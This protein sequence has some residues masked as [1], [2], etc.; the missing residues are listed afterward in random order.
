M[1]SITCP[2]KDSAKNFPKLPA[3][4]S[5]AKELSFEELD[6]LVDTIAI[7]L[8][9]HSLSAGSRLGILSKNSENMLATIFA[10]Q[11]IGATSCLLNLQL[12][13]D[14]WVS[15][16]EQAKCSVIIGEDEYL[17]SLSSERQ[18]KLDFQEITKATDTE[19]EILFELNPSQE[20][21]IIFT[22][23][24]TGHNKGVRLSV[25]NLM[26]SAEA[27]NKLT[28]LTKGD[29]WGVSLPMYHLGGLGIIYRTLSAGA[30]AGFLSN[31]SAE[32]LHQLLKENSLTHLSVVPTTLSA[33]IE[34]ATQDSLGDKLLGSLKCAILAGAASSETL[35]NQII[36]HKLPI[37]SAWGMTETTAHCTCMNLDEPKEHIKS[38]GKPFHHTQLKI[39]NEEGEEVAQGQTGEAIVNGPTV[40]M[41][42]L[43][44]EQTANTIKNGWLHSG[45]LGIIN[46]DGYLTIVGRKDDMIISGG[47]NIHTG[48]IEKVAKAIEGVRDCAVIPIKH[49]KWGQRPIILVEPKANS[50]L[51]EEFISDIL[52]TKLAKIKVPDRVIFRTALPRTSIGKVNYKILK[53]EFQ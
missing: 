49:E 44:T 30:T 35:L 29:T 14:D 15:Q 6:K 3:I 21:V 36:K 19:T 13:K 52:K 42:Y 43:D 40:F 10:A 12:T 45:D 20:S 2:I 5:N 17:S 16:L 34:K 8:V 46:S 4:R 38:V 32:T 1:I 18:T 48:E 24:S 31:F 23:G 47:E 22:S 25:R 37:L 9:R 51:T 33:L 27:S 39:V 26:S 7:N 28:K 41:G 11:R 50:N 53:A